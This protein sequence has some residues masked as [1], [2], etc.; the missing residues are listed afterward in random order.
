MFA[1]VSRRERYESRTQVIFAL[2]ASLAFGISA[3]LCSMYIA[4]G[5]FS[6][7][8]FV[9]YFG[10]AYVLMLNLLPPAILSVVFYLLFNRAVW[11][12]VA[13]T[14]A[15]IIPTTVHYFKLNLRGDPLLFAD[16]SL[17][18]ETAK[19]LETYELFIDLRLGIYI[20]IFVL[21][22]VALIF[23]K[24]RFKRIAPRLISAVCILLASLFLTPL[25]TSDE[26]YTVKASNTAL[27]N[28][29]SDTHQYISKGF[30]YPFLHSV[31]TAFSPAPDSYS[32]SEAEEIL[33]QY[34]DEV[35]P[36]DKKVDIV[37]VM[38]EAFND[39]SRFEELS[40]NKDIYEKYHLLESIGVS[41]NLITDIFAGD[42]RVSEREF[43]TGLPYARLDDFNKKSNSYMWYLRENGYQVTG[44]HP[45]YGWF[46]NRE[47]INKNLGFESYL[48]SENYFKEITEVDIT[49]DYKFF[50]LFHEL[51]ATRD[52]SRPY[53]SYALTYQGHGP[54][55]TDVENYDGLIVQ[56]PEGISLESERIMNNYLHSISSTV[57]HLYNF[58]I[59]MYWQSD[60][61]VLVFFGDHKPYLGADGEVYTDYGINLD[62]STADGFENYY[63]TR[64][65]IIANDAAKE[66]TGNAFLGE[67][68]T[69]SASFLMNKVF[70]LCGYKGNAYM[71]FTSDI[72]SRTPV[73]HRTADLSYGDA[74]LFDCV[75][76]YYRKN[77]IYN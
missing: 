60:P 62:T 13:T 34:E 45:S 5:T 24:G 71:Q 53:F 1:T 68:E 8:M 39:F 51:Y 14:V 32:K 3:G 49:Y 66:I 56:S 18:G 27:I 36:N 15:V 7:Q 33:A 61:V 47:N 52:K 11:S 40:F 12:Y 50:Q 65:I 67:G 22:T 41:G 46:Y 37:C 76:Y 73:I 42:T 48:F 59:N 72:M 28:P 38:L 35:I 29:W 44:A 10:N 57:E 16:L 70:E 75:S 30:V 54:Y 77:F 26:I 2:V 17:V 55:E 23:V 31:K 4:T 19:M 9:S 58:V 63:G 21:S 64:Y 25:Y 74:R 20:G 6:I 69:I 43:L